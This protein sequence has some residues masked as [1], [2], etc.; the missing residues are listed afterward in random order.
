MRR[1]RTENSGNVLLACFTFIFMCS[2]FFN[3]LVLYKAVEQITGATVSLKGTVSITVMPACRIDLFE[4]WNYISLCARP[5]NTSIK[6]VLQN[7]PYRYVMVWNE[8][9][10][11]FEIYS[12]RAADPPFE[13][14]DLN[15]SYFI[16][17]TNNSLLS[18]RGDEFG[19][20]NISLLQGWNPPTWPYLFTANISCY[21][22]SIADKYRYVMKWNHSS[23]EFIIYSPKAAEPQFTTIS[24]GEGQF[25]LITDPAGAVLCYNKSAC[26][27]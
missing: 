10:Q 23:Q 8:S 26:K 27:P 22:S 14:F 3:Q 17:I 5:A 16:L 18:V 11:A 20:M 19:D 6:A 4:G 15:K 1:N 9:K 2:T 21:L 24:C 13:N 12:P 25:I 7:I